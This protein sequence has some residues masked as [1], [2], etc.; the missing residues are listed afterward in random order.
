ML[1]VEHHDAIVNLL[2]TNAICI[3]H[4]AAPIARESV[5]VDVDDID[6]A[7]PQSDSLL[8]HS[9][10]FINQRVDGSFE[11]LS[12]V[13][14]PRANT[15]VRGHLMNQLDHVG[16]RNR[17]AIALVAVPPLSCFLAEATH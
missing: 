1:T 2:E 15:G 5:S 4:R 6:I 3:E 12:V 10:A 16:I 17:F 7:G 14:K 9:S 8:E 13:Q 11:N